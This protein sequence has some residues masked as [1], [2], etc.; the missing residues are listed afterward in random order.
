[1]AR[2]APAWPAIAGTLLALSV[3]CWPATAD[4]PVSA[5][6]DFAVYGDKNADHLIQ[7]RPNIRIPDNGELNWPLF[8]PDT[9]V[10]KDVKLVV[11]G[12]YHPYA[13]D[14]VIQL[15]HNDRVVDV[16]NR[17]AGDKHVGLPNPFPHPNVAGPE[18]PPSTGTGF[19]YVFEDA[20]GNNLAYGKTT[21]QT[22]TQFGGVSSRAVDG[23]VA[24]HFSDGSVTHTG[25]PTGTDPQ[26]YWQVD[27]GQDFVVGTIRVWNRQDELETDEVQ[28]VRTQASGT[29]AG[30]FKLSF[31]NHNTTTTT[32]FISVHA[33]ASLADENKTSSEAGLGLG[34]SMQAKIQA[35]PNVGQVAVSRSPPD[36]RGGYEWSITFL[37][38]PGDLTEMLVANN[39]VTSADGLVT[40]RTPI[41]GSSIIWQNEEGEQIAVSGR[42]TPAYVMLLPNG[43]DLDGSL[44]STREQASWNTLMTENKRQTVFTLPTNTSGRYIRIQLTSP[45]DYLSLA[46]VQVY[47]EE[48]DSFCSYRGGSPIPKG[49]YYGVESLQE[50]FL[51]VDSYGEWILTIDDVT[52]VSVA[53]K[54]SSRPEKNV[55]GYGGLQWWTLDLIDA[56]GNTLRYHSDIKFEITTLPTWGTLYNWNSTAAV[57]SGGFAIVEGRQQ[58]LAECYENCRARFNVGNRLSTNL[59]GSVTAI[60]RITAEDHARSVLYVPNTGYLGQDSFTYIVL[61]G[62]T[63]S[64]RGTVTVHTRKC[65]NTPLCFNEYFDDLLLVRRD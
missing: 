22:S 27:L 57:K 18:F 32:A 26:P 33:V 23:N 42:L 9:F 60:N 6:S 4:A 53:E 11:T 39:S 46:E 24:G 64:A 56:G 41:A 29:L 40:V 30:Q 54:N 7:L 12:L 25:N 44:N 28:V 37:S 21:T 47:T 62:V 50:G 17:C 20:L 43:T 59:D 49:N 48:A 35:L 38:E 16:V 15:R 13:E 3:C 8:V 52:Q 51:D 63:P 5:A 2:V 10:V 31:H 19:R 45:T 58:Y 34:E 65:R 1:M 61:V 14:L 36:P 55:N